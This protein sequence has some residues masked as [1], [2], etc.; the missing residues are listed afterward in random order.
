MS[1]RPDFLN[2]C[3]VLFSGMGLSVQGFT[4][5]NDDPLLA[6]FRVEQFEKQ[7]SDEENPIVLDASAWL[8][9]DLNKLWIKTEFERAGGETEELEIQALYGRAIHPYWD[10]QLGLRTDLEPEPE[11]HWA[12]L[13]INGLAPYFFEVDASLFVSED[14]DSALRIEAEYELMLTQRWALTPEME[15][16]F[17]GENN[18]EYL[19]GSGLASAEF[20]LR[21][22]YEIRREF[23][24]YI[25][26]TTE[27]SYGRTQDYLIAAG[28]ESS[29][30]RAVVGLS[31]WF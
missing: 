21:L 6:M 30:T 19:Q 15:V 23:A 12:V 8:G 5:G 24:P 4:H 10:L 14:G 16:D 31:F 27:K 20:G 22:R 3:A 26:V 17:Y 25:G 11:R 28:E 2:M 18:V 7:F 1:K 29:E 9:Y 13:G